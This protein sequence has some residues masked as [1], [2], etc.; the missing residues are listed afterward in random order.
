VAISKV[1]EPVHS[2][3]PFPELRNAGANGNHIVQFYE[4]E[5]FLARTVAD[6][7]GA[8]FKDHQPA[9][10]IATPEHRE[11]IADS[12]NTRGIDINQARNSGSLT[13]LDARQTLAQF[14]VGGSPDRDSFQRVIGQALR[15]SRRDSRSVIRAYGEMVDILWKE[16]N[17]GGAIRLEQLWNELAQTYEFSLL[18]AYA[19]ANFYKSADSDSFHAICHTHSHVRPTERYTGANEALR[20]IE[21]TLLQ[22]RANALEN[23][24]RHREELEHR[25]RQTVAS[26]H[27]RE[28]EREQLLQA[29]R[30]ARA[31]AQRAQAL[32]EQA[33]RSKSEFLAVMSHELRTPLNAIGGYAELMQLGLHGAVNE[34][35]AEALERIQ[36]SQ[37][38]LLGL[39]NQVLNYA[40]LET[41]NVR[42]ELTSVS[43]DDI[44][45]T[46]DA[47]VMPQM[48][49]KGL[50]YAYLACE[51]N[52]T[53]RA[54]SEKFQ[55]IVLNLLTNAVKFTE[56]GGQVRVE[57]EA[58]GSNAV[59]MIHD[60]GIGIP[61]EKIDLIFDPFV[62]VDSNFT[63]T[64][65]G[66]GLGLAISRDLARGMSGELTANSVLGR[67]TTMALTL[68]LA[69]G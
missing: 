58:V 42:Y 46:A 34:G 6:F 32:A 65:E 53:V 35:Q 52:L 29:E 23:E 69:R 38:H 66:V 41:G 26:L 51:Q 33:N 36:R 57:C 60:T 9:I 22:Q 48:R 25:L 59:I 15:A 63:R 12:L 68:P 21:I 49:A 14:M 61:A 27:S 11:A 67:G 54:D 10:I 20:L 55:Q 47:L 37:R 28:K 45:R 2:L 7:V 50:R 44:L 16:G 64:R 4:D 39:I 3:E 13:M 19:M 56:R 31:E 18:C 5:A 24:I 1:F 30:D 40:R 17:T 43:V 8:G 62:Q